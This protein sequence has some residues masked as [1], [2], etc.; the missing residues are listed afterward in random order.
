M[1]LNYSFFIVLYS[2]FHVPWNKIEWLERKIQPHLDLAQPIKNDGLVV[3]N[4]KLWSLKKEIFI[5]EYIQPYV[6]IF[7][8]AKNH[9]RKWCYFD[10]FSGSGLFDLEIP[11]N[12]V[13]FPGS[14]LLSYSRHE[15]FPFSEYYFADGKKVMLNH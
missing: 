6:N 9:F 11:G 14:P 13:K 3:S 4:G 1:I 15:N 8:S 10:P 7:K 12:K 5:Y 2:Y